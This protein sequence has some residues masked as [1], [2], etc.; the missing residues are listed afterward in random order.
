MKWIDIK[1]LN[2][3]E[4]Q[5]ALKDARSEL[6]DLKFKIASGSLKQVRE[7]RKSK[8][9]IAYAFNNQNSW[10]RSL[11]RVRSFYNNVRY[12]FRYIIIWGKFQGTKIFTIYYG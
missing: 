5:K 4:V 8:K 10:C 1:N 3:V 11:W 6:V 7:I 2:E 9:S 12:S